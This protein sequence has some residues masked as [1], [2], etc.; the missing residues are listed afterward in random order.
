M[1]FAKFVVDAGVEQDAFGGG[2]FPCIDVAEIPM[3]R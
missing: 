1:G 2:G 3:L